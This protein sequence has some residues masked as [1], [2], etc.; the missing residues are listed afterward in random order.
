MNAHCKRALRYLLILI[1]GLTNITIL[2][3][4]ACVMVFSITSKPA[5]GL[6][7]SAVVVGFAAGVLLTV[8]EVQ[9]VRWLRKR[10]IF[11]PP[12]TRVQ[13]SCP[14]PG[15]QYITEKDGLCPE[16]FTLLESRTRENRPAP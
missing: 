11:V 7:Y 12:L 6:L 14:H 3:F 2:S 13:Y 1:V 10:D 5:D 15:C 9:H 4:L 8:Q 16:H